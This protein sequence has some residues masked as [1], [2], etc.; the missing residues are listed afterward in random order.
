MRHNIQIRRCSNS[1]IQDFWHRL[2]IGFI[3]AL[4]ILILELIH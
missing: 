2:R 1:A 4:V 3:L